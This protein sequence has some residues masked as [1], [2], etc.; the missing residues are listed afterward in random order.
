MVSSCGQWPQIGSQHANGF[1]AVMLQLT[2]LQFTKT[3][4]NIFQRFERFCFYLLRRS[5][6]ICTR[7]TSK[8]LFKQICS[9]AVF[10]V[11]PRSIGSGQIQLWQFLLELL[12]DQSNNS[13]IAWEGQNGEFK[14][15]DPDEVA[16]RWGE[17]KSKVKKSFYLFC[18]QNS[19]ASL[20]L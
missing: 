6:F 10:L 8:K 15:S 18:N 7:Q 14:L 16:R 13:F 19:S 5:F 3:F 11:S 20:S 4:S 1:H 17:R 2:E 9:F 12:A